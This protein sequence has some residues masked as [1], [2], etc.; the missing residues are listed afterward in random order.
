MIPPPPRATLLP[1]TTLLRPQDHG[2][3][4]HQDGRNDRRHRTL[5]LSDEAHILHSLVLLRLS[6]LGLVQGT[7]RLR[8]S[9]PLG[10]RENQIPGAVTERKATNTADIGAR[11]TRPRS[12]T[13]RTGPVVYGLD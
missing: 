12:G 10:A 3:R 13:G 7:P 2:N 5:V 8:L 9:L 6:P 4:D 1:H 11:G